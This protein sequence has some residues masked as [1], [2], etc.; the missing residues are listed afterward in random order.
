MEVGTEAALRAGLQ[1]GRHALTPPGLQETREAHSSLQWE[2]GAGGVVMPEWGP[3]GGSPSP[4]LVLRA[5]FPEGTFIRSK[6]G[7]QRG[8]LD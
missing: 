1:D 8:S 4:S 2:A 3:P 6:Q 5:C 7:R